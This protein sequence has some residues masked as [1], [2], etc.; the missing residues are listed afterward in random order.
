MSMVTITRSAPNAS[1]A[2][3]RARKT[4]LARTSL[5][6]M[7]SAENARP[8]LRLLDAGR[9]QVALAGTI[10]QAAAIYLI[11]IGGRVAQ[12]DHLAA[13]LHGSHENLGFALRLRGKCGGQ[14]ES[15]ENHEVSTSG[16]HRHPDRAR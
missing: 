3:S 2:V 6:G 1:S 16:V 4:G 9:R 7:R 10:A 12:I 11:L 15:Y 5:T 13:I 8:L 14:Q